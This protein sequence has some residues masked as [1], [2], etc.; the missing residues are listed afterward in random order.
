MAFYLVSIDELRLVLEILA[1]LPRHIP[2][3][4]APNIAARLGWTMQAK[5][6][7]ETNLPVNI[8]YFGFVGMSTPSGERELVSVDFRVSD[9]VTGDTEEAS[10]SMVDKAFP[11]AVAMVT[12]CLGFAPT[13]Q[14]PWDTPGET[15][16]LPGE[17]QVNLLQDS[18]VI[19]EIESQRLTDLE[20]DQIHRGE[21]I[22]WAD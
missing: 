10:Q 11:L 16:D 4:D 20:M 19:L 13:R 21:P 2:L 18:A 14:R 17:G 22:T 9:T 5:N 8:R 6:V 3:T 7:G 1:P 15:W 12:E